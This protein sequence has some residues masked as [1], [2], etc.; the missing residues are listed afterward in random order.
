MRF[1]TFASLV[2][3]SMGLVACGNDSDTE[4]RISVPSDYPTI[5]EAVKNARPGTII[6]VD[7]GT[8]HEAV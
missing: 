7:P 5:T 6:E 4:R 1:A 2:I 8:Y 3:A